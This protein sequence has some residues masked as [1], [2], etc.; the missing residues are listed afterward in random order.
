MEEQTSMNTIS[1]KFPI[2]FL[3]DISGSM[4]GKS[5]QIVN[6]TIN[7]FCEWACSEPAASQI[8]D[9]AVISFN[10]E[11]KIDRPFMPVNRMEELNL[12]TDG[13]TLFVP[14]VELAVRLVEE[15]IQQYRLHGVATVT[16]WILLFSDGDASDVRAAIKTVRL[17]T[18]KRLFKM[19]ALG[20]EE[21][22]NRVLQQLCDGMVIELSNSSVL[23]ELFHWLAN[24]Y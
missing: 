6:E 11:T 4:S 24:V 5:I 22:N 12:S 7:R 17:E 14:A 10:H 23:V 20:V 2:L 1:V 18:D 13:G 16:P 15:Q 8:L 3:V 21:Y 19:I 9:V